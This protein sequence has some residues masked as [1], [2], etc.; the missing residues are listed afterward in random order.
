[1]LYLLF[2]LTV[3]GIGYLLIKFK[4]RSIFGGLL[5]AAGLILSFFTLLILGLVFLDKTSSHGSMLALAIFYLLIPLIFLAVCIYLIL[6]SQTMR[7]KEGKSLTAKLSAVMGLNLIIS[8]PLFVFL[9]TGVFKLPL[10]LNIILLFIL[11]LDLILSFIF[12]AYLFYS[13]MYQMLP[14]KKHIDYIIVLGSGISS[15][16]V[17]PLLKSRLDKGIEYFYKNPNAKFVVSGGQGAD[18]PVSEAYAMR[19]YLLSQHIPEDKIILE[20]QS[21]TT[22]ENMLFSKQL[23]EEDWLTRFEAEHPKPSIIFSTNNYHVLRA[24][25]YA[26]RVHLKAEGVGAPTAL[27]FLPTALIREYIALLS[28]NKIWVM[29]LIGFVFLIL[30]YSFFDFII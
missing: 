26:R 14:L 8:F 13:W 5:F 22:Y 11:L 30:L 1:M 17:P 10:F 16:D 2:F 19:K 18:E 21:T 3:S 20:D 4:D 29:G 24:R 15:E 27:Y 23:I 9:I 6:N 28:H 12:I 7:T 25:L